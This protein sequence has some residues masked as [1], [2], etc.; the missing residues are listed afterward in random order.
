MVEKYVERVHNT[1]VLDIGDDIGA[2]II[3]TNE[4]LRGIQIDVS[5]Q[6]N[7]SAKRIHTDVLERRIGE[8]PVFAAVFAA[9]P[10]GNYITWSDPAIAFTIIGGQIAELD[11]RTADVYVP[12]VSAAAMG[13]S[14]TSQRGT[15]SS[16]M[17]N[18]LPPRYQGGKKVSSAPMGTAP[19][20]YTDGGQVAWNDMWTD[21]CDL[22]LAGGP[23]HRD[24]LLEPVAPDEVKANLPAYE[25]VINEIE[26]GLRLVTG[27]P[28]IRSERLGWIGLKCADEEMALWLLRAIIVENVCVRREG[29]VLFL[30]VGPDFKMDKEIKNVIT[31]VAKTHHYWMEHMSAQINMAASQ[32]F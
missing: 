21:F 30:P 6:G 32:A 23:P 24:T 9:L 29:T 31:V 13:E 25:Q 18:I 26:R 3:Y 2:L 27:L 12:P 19:M 15:A 4:N 20:R 22:A 28:I 10:E 7:V 8:R 16:A 14:G 11:W 1:I 17:S 5:P